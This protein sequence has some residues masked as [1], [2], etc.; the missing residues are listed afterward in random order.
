IR[1]AFG[2]NNLDRDRVFPCA[3]A[4]RLGTR[5]S[6]GTWDNP[7][8]PTRRRKPGHPDCTMSRRTRRAVHPLNW[9]R[10]RAR[11]PPRTA[12]R[13]VALQAAVQEQAL[14]GQMRSLRVAALHRQNEKLLVLNTIAL[15]RTLGRELLLAAKERVFAVVLDECENGARVGD[16]VLD[17]CLDRILR[18]DRRVLGFFLVP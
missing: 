5:S 1:K 3:Y 15:E 17:R 16:H 2:E 6:V 8:N 11:P 4:S 9:Y 14:A 12:R 13:P 10:G 18:P 7:G